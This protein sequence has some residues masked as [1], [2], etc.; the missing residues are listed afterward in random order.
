MFDPLIGAD[1]AGKPSAKFRLLES[2]VLSADARTFTMTLRKGAKWQDGAE[3]TSDDLNHLWVLGAQGVKVHY[4]RVPQSQY[5]PYR[6]RRP[7]HRKTHSEATER[8]LGE[9]VRAH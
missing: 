9:L 3:I 1:P 4:L 8:D 2:Y 7:V 5:G 6:D